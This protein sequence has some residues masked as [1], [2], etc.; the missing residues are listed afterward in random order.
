VHRPS[1][2][3]IAKARHFPHREYV[4][5]EVCQGGE[6]LVDGEVDILRR[7]A[8]AFVH[9]HRWLGVPQALAM[10]IERE[11][12]GDVKQPRPDLAVGSHGDGC[13]AH[14]QEDVLRQITRGLDLA[15]RPAEVLEQ[16]MMVGG[17][18]R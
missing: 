9:Q 12:S 1:D 15:D 13:P 2:L 7:Q 11:V 17:E 14:P 3:V 6:G 10:V 4:T 8:R 18:E 16:A 5:V